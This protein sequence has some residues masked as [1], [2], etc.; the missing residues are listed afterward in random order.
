MDLASEHPPLAAD[1]DVDVCVVGGGLAGLTVAR[2]LAR[3]RWSVAVLEARRIAWNASGCGIGLV[4]PGFAQFPARIV[5]RLG[6][7][8]AKTLWALSTAGVEYVRRTAEEIMSPLRQGA[9]CLTVYRT[10]EDAVGQ[11]CLGLLQDTF[12]SNVEYWDTE[13]VRSVLQSRTYRHAAYFPTAFHLDQRSYALTLA[14]AAQAAGVRIFEGTPAHAL[15]CAGVRKHV[16][17]PTGRIRAGHVVLAGGAQAAALMPR[18]AETLL[19]LPGGM[20]MTLPLG[21]PVRR[22]IGFAGAIRDPDG[23]ACYRLAD[24]DRLLWSGRLATPFR[25]GAPVLRQLRSNIVSTFPQLRGFEAASAYTATAACAVHKMPQ[26][27]EL[28]PGLWIANAFAD[29]GINTTAMAADLIAG[30]IVHGDDRWRLFASYGLVWAGGRAGRVAAELA[31]RATR[32]GV[33][34][35]GLRARWPRTAAHVMRAGV[36][37]S[38]AVTRPIAIPG[39]AS[40]SAAVTRPITVPGPQVL[41]QRAPEPPQSARRKSAPRRKKPKAT[42]QQRTRKVKAPAL[43]PESTGEPLEIQPNRPTA[44]L[45][46][47]ST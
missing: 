36:A 12:E 31:W 33:L 39:D 9:G 44:P 5:E 4:V 24:G 43:A 15:D 3:R 23:G 40:F 45:D 28:A 29:Q 14:T 34:L 26:I 42:H 6:I 37:S 47:S 17:T 30:A 20:L 11:A 18:L 35:S 13:R 25:R 1:I 10:G 32:T 27:G 16:E 46:R 38:T 41:Q 22:T 8:R 19:P 21:E 2:E 7:A